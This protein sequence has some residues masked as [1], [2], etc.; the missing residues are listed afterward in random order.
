MQDNITNSKRIRSSSTL[1]D[2]RGLL[3]KKIIAVNEISPVYGDMPSAQ[4]AT[5][6]VNIANFST[7]NTIV[8]VWVS[9][10]DI[11]DDID[12][13]EPGIVLKANGVF[14]RSGLIISGHERIF[15]TT[16]VSPVVVR[17]EGVED[18]LP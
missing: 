3:G 9:D 15:C 4:F 7:V 8:R 1:L 17:I 16:T 2:K 10:K 6:S 18:R 14:L 11:P 12:I 5:V 13:I